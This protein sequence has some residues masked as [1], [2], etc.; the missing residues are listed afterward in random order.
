MVLKR[1]DAVTWLSL[2]MLLWGLIT[3]IMAFA[4]NFASLLACRLLLG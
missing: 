3:V 1:T 2:I 4:N